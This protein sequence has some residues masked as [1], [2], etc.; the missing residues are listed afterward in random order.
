MRL[1][2]SSIMPPIFTTYCVESTLPLIQL[3][4]L[5][6]IPAQADADPAT[7]NTTNNNAIFFM[8]P[9]LFP[10]LLLIGLCPLKRNRAC[11]ST[12]SV[13][14]LSEALQKKYRPERDKTKGRM[15]F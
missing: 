3:S 7:N 5:G 4:V 12:Q 6:H 2:P 15:R 13:T 14:G 11:F 1:T 9:S 8:A 10:R